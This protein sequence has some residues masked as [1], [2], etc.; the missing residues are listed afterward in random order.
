MARSDMSNLWG[1]EPP[2]PPD[3][4]VLTERRTVVKAFGQAFDMGPTEALAFAERLEAIARAIREQ[5]ARD[6]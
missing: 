6:G 2:L 5:T 4:E 1:V 3:Y